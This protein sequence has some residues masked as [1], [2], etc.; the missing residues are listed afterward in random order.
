MVP[1]AASS[2][3]PFFIRSL[4]PSR[5]V[6]LCPPPLLVCR[7]PF[8][9]RS[10]VPS[11]GQ[12]KWTVIGGWSCRNPFFIRSLVPSRRKPHLHLPQTSEVA[13][14]SSSG[15]W[16]LPPQA[17]HI[18]TPTQWC[19][20][21]FFIRSLVPSLSNFEGRKERSPCRN[22]FFIRSLVPSCARAAPLHTKSV[23]RN[24]FFIRSLVPSSL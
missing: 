2:R 1:P 15:H 23:S 5:R 6:C 9:I 22:P 16:F 18:Q 12:P 11:R 13:I 10:L 8:F 20:N 24:P 4:V 21:P 7:N 19:R 3:N 14:P 17:T